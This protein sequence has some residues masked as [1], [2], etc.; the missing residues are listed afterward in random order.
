M[1]NTS[2]FAPNLAKT[3]LHAKIEGGVSFGNLNKIWRELYAPDRRYKI[4]FRAASTNT[5][6]MSIGKSEFIVEFYNGAVYCRAIHNDLYNRKACFVCYKDTLACDYRV[7][8]QYD[9]L[10]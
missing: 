8:Y 2:Y 9:Y 6:I 10:I 3:F 7:E 4:W 5:Y 1:Y